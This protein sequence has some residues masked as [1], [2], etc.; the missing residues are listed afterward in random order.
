MKR[1]GIEPRQLPT[2]AFFHENIRCAFVP[3]SIW[4]VAAMGRVNVTTNFQQHKLVDIRKEVR[5][6]SE[7][8]IASPDLNVDIQPFTR[9]VFGNL[10]MTGRP[11]TDGVSARNPRGV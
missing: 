6:P 5:A 7:W 2:R 9:E 3:S 1:Y 11:V 4:V 8:H 10:V